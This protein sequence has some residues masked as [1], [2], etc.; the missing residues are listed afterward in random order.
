MMKRK[1]KE[2]HTDEVHENGGAFSCTSPAAGSDEDQ[3]EKTKELYAYLTGAGLPEGVTCPTPKLDSNVAFS[4]IWFLQEVTG[5]LPDHFE[6]CCECDD[7]FDTHCA[8]DYDEKT[9][10]HRCD[11]CLGYY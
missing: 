1:S 4:V 2:L 10:E 7:I 5:V 11:S 9:G 8:G 3:L 6:K